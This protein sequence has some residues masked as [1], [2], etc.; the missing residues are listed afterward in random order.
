MKGLPFISP[1]TLSQEKRMTLWTNTFHRSIKQT[2]KTIL[3]TARN[4]NKTRCESSDDD[5]AA[6]DDDVDDD[7]DDVDDDDV[8]DD[9]VDDDDVDDILNK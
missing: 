9:D 4:S 7:D 3:L 2:F 8:D 6:A 1:T 5:V